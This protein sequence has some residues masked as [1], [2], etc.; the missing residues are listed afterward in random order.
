MLASLLVVNFLPFTVGESNENDAEVWFHDIDYETDDSDGEYGNESI[1]I[2]FDLETDSNDIESAI[3]E[4]NVWRGDDEIIDEIV[5]D[6][7]VVHNDSYYH[8]MFWTAPDRDYFCFELWIHDTDE[9]EWF[10]EELGNHENNE[11]DYEVWFEDIYYETDDS[12][13]EDGNETMHISFDLNTTS[14]DTV[15][16]TVQI[17]VWRGD[18]EIIVETDENYEVHSNDTY[19]HNF[20]WSASDRD[21][22]CFDLWIHDTDEEEWFCEELGNHENNEEDYEVWFEDIYYETDDS[23]GEDGNETIHISFDLDTDSEDAVEATVRINVWRGDDEVIAEIDENYEVHSND[24]YYHNFSWSAADRDLYCFE[25]K[26]YDTD[27]EEWFC[28]EL[29]NYEENEEDYEIWFEYSYY[30]TDDSDGQVNGDETIHIYFDLESNTEETVEATVQ[31]NVWRGN[32]EVIEEIVATYEVP[33]NETY[34]HQLS[35]S[36]SDRDL[37]CF[38]LW[39]HDTDE[40]EWFCEELGNHEEDDE[41]NAPEL[42]EGWVTPQEGT[43]EDDFRF[44]VIY[45]D[46]DDTLPE[47]VKLRLLREGTNDFENYQMEEGHPEYNSTGDHCDEGYYSWYHFIMTGSDIGIGSHEYSFIASDSEDVVDTDWY[48]G[49][50]VTEADEGVDSEYGVIVAIEPP[51]RQVQ[52]GDVANFVITVLNTGNVEDTFDVSYQTLFANTSASGWQVSMAENEVTIASGMYATITL[53]VSVPQSAQSNDT[54]IFKVMA[55]SQ[56]DAPTDGSAFASVL[57][58]DQMFTI[59]GL[60]VVGTFAALGSAGVVAPFRRYLRNR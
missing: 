42:F 43:T 50:T 47:F 3:V 14:E 16:A 1:S 39:I 21:L 20:S 31:M 27:E 44:E 55:V 41:N 12:D 57:V 54:F 25:M 45:C 24:T 40:E 30:E 28:E 13:G 5:E 52:S 15:E 26:I 59:P 8:E 60:G 4:L 7:D 17:N 56:S 29:G 23:D 10:C 38:E 51:S 9:E 33:H 19:Y 37:Y 46:V 2:L 49:P 36:A 11:E 35:W 58:S 32:D 6:Y 34:Y 18:D 22:Y 53:T 48:D